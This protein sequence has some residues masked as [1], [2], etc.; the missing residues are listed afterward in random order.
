[1]GKQQ[2]PLSVVCVWGFIQLLLL[3]PGVINESWGNHYHGAPQGVTP[4]LR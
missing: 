3:Q 4:R 2:N 1:M